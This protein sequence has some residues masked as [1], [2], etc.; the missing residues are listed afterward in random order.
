MYNEYIQFCGHE[1][2]APLKC[3]AI[4]HNNNLVTIIFDNNRP[5]NDILLSG[6]RLLNP[7]DDFS[8]MT[9]DIY[10]NYTTLYREVDDNTVMLSSDGSVY[11]EPQTD[12]YKP[13]EEELK[14]QEKE[15]KIQ[16]IKNKIS[17]LKAELSST[18]YIFIK[19]AESSIVGESITDE[20][21]FEKLHEDRQKIRDNINVLESEL[22]NM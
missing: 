21:D 20:Y 3:T 10:I 18:D 19:Y 14:A 9:G 7:S 4:D 8:D 6:Y 1:D 16:E 5:N 13:T 2:L 22:S 11:I 15:L 17:E 12:Q